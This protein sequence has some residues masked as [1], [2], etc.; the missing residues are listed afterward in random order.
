MKILKRYFLKITNKTQNETIRSKSSQLKS[1]KN[2]QTFFIDTSYILVYAS[3]KLANCH[4]DMKQI[5][6]KVCTISVK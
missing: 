5:K 2:Q 6:T 1:L 4:K 3:K